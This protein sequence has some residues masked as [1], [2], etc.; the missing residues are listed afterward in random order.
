MQRIGLEHGKEWARRI[1][2]FS[3]R[4]T[5]GFTDAG[6]WDGRLV[7]CHD[8]GVSPDGSVAFTTML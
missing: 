6:R 1:F 7:L 4:G 3:E 5:G 2:I 8:D